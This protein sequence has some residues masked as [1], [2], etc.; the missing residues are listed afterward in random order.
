MASEIIFFLYLFTNLA[1][2]LSWQSIK[3]RG[4][5]KNNLFDR[6]LLKEHFC[7]RISKYLQ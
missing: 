5:D 3:F 4:L 1:F 6:E 7:K 2:Q